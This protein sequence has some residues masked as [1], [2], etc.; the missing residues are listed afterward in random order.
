VCTVCEPFTYTPLLGKV[1]KKRNA[2]RSVQND[3]EAPYAVL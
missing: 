2:A 1:E 3:D